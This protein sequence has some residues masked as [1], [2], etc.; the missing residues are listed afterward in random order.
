MRQSAFQ[1]EFYIIYNKLLSLIDKHQKHEEKDISNKIYNQ[2]NILLFAKQSIYFT[3]YHIKKLTLDEDIVIS[4]FFLDSLYSTRNQA[5]NSFSNTIFLV[6]SQ[7]HNLPAIEL[8][9]V[10]EST[11]DAEN[12][13][14][15]NFP[16]QSIYHDYRQ[17]N[18]YIID[19]YKLSIYSFTHYIQGILCEK[20][21]DIAF[22]NQLFTEGREL[23]LKSLN[24]LSHLPK[25]DYNSLNAEKSLYTLLFKPL[26]IYRNDLRWIDFEIY[27]INFIKNLNDKIEQLE[28]SFNL[29]PSHI[30]NIF[31]KIWQLYI[32]RQSSYLSHFLTQLA[33]SD[34]ILHWGENKK[35]SLV[36]K[37]NSLLL[38]IEQNIFSILYSIKDKT[39]N[40]KELTEELE[41]NKNL[42]PS[43]IFEES[44]KMIIPYE[45]SSMF[46][47]FYTS[48]F[49]TI[50]VSFE[51]CIK[52]LN[53]STLFEEP[54]FHSKQISSFLQNLHNTD[55]IIAF[56]EHLVEKF[57]STDWLEYTKPDASH[58]LEQNNHCSI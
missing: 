3:E 16:L 42:K 18:K 1:N 25:S 48:S 54:L 6:Y 31:F 40:I 32:V 11:I 46:F 49:H 8:E 43:M 12:F 10:L 52:S 5:L 24:I 26:E 14:N 56:E 20:L 38:G 9:K 2:I 39:A 45:L 55:G 33:T 7:I 28:E 35:N 47:G 44:L 17:N 34:S 41:S 4:Y 19:F 21:G 30:Y 57:F 51:F 36:H 58:N 50:I 15:N 53:T 27:L 37:K 29:Y 22:K 13:L 23:Q